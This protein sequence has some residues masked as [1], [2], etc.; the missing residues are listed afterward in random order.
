GVADG[1]VAAV[2]AH[3]SGVVRQQ[4]AGRGL[5][6]RGPQDAPQPAAAERDA[7]GGQVVQRLGAAGGQ[8]VEA[9]APPPE[10][11]DHHVRLA[12]QVAPAAFSP[13]HRHA[14]DVTGGRR[15]ARARPVGP[16][17]PPAAT[18]APCPA[19]PTA[20]RPAATTTTPAATPSSSPP[21][22]PCATPC[23][24]PCRRPASPASR[25][26]AT[27][28]RT[29]R[30]P[31]PPPSGCGPPRSGPGPARSRPTPTRPSCR[32]ASGPSRTARRS[33]WPCPGWPSP[34]RSAC[35]TPTTSP[36]PRASRSA[37]RVA[38]ED[39]DPVDLVVVGCVAVGADGA[40][41]GKG[42]GFADLELALATAA[43]L[44]GPGTVVVT[45]VHELQVRPAGEI[46]TT[47]HDVP[48]DLVVTPERVLDCRPGRAPRPEARLRWEE[49]TDEKVAAIPLLRRLRDRA[50]AG[51]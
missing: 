1:V 12:E 49:L 9:A 33:S 22:R 19:V 50:G 23:G 7:R 31:R 20:G 18:M 17:A 28:S 27:A 44:V 38:V 26:P 37:R 25:A 29:S 51:G 2:A 41:L 3:A 34:T 47:D 36:T 8:V 13:D 46:P 15:T 42:G 35:S 5:L 24:R 10:P 48:V 39:L 4:L 43:G 11:A 30:V 16:A 14:G 21:R 6:A 40:R 32:C 45:T